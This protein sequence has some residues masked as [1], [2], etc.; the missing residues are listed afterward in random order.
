MVSFKLWP[1]CPKERGPRIYLLG[2]R[3]GFIVGPETLEK[4]KI[5]CKLKG[6]TIFTKISITIECTD[7]I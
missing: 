5:V 2:R 1:M 4:N 3:M 7:F 6:G